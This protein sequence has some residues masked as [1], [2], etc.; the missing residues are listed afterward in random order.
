VVRPPHGEPP[1]PSAPGPHGPGG[2]GSG[3]FP[4]VPQNISA[5][6]GLGGAG[7]VAL[8]GA[9]DRLETISPIPTAISTAIDAFAKR[10]NLSFIFE[11]RKQFQNHCSAAWKLLPLLPHFNSEPPPGRN[12]RSSDRQIGADVRFGSITAAPR[13]EKRG[14]CCSDSCRTRLPPSRQFWAS[15]GHW[16]LK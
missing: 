5:Q 8:A 1:E 13:H 2:V 9:T 3:T 16:L 11:P 10:M 12:I 6:T 15:N 7:S 4:P 14:R